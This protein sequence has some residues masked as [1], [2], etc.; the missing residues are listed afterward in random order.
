MTTWNH[1]VVRKVQSGV[2]GLFCLLALLC[3]QVHLM[4]SLLALVALLDASHQVSVTLDEGKFT[5]ALHHE[6][7]QPGRAD[8][9]PQRDPCN[10]SHKHGLVARCVCALS[11]SNDQIPDHVACF[12]SGLAS[13]KSLSVATPKAQSRELFGHLDADVFSVAGNA[14]SPK[15]PQREAHAPPISSV[16]QSLRSVTLLI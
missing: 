6:R 9:A 3:G 11:S 5:V 4:P 14:V 8:Y 16:L 2:G 13:E 7:A 10:A 12:A 1:R 15:L